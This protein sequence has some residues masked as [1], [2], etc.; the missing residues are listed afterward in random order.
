[1]SHAS[2]TI[3]SVAQLGVDIEV[4]ADASQASVTLLEVARIVVRDHMPL[5]M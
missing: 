3:L 1:M 5:S 2:V 4:G